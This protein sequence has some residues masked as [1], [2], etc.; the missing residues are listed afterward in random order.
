MTTD[1]YRG[2][3]SALM[4]HHHVQQQHIQSSHTDGANYLAANAHT[5]TDGDTIDI[6]TTH[7][8]TSRWFVLPGLTDMAAN[9][10]TVF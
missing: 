4:V 1:E 6:T 8:E 5:V 2:T 10:H 9:E 3:Y 7:T